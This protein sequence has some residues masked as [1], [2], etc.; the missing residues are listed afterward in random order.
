M[1]QCNT[2]KVNYLCFPSQMQKKKKKKEK[3]Q[4]NI[5]FKKLMIWIKTVVLHY[6]F[7]LFLF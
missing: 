6:I 7:Y 1:M 2:G 4:A 5:E 3:I